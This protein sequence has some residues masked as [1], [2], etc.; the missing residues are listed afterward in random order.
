MTTT[1]TSLEILDDVDRLAYL[2][3]LIKDATTEADSIK[4]RLRDDYA[5]N[6]GTHEVGT[7]RLSVTTSLRFSEDKARAALPAD[8]IDAC[9]VAK[10][11]GALVKKV[12]APLVY[13]ALCD[14]STPRVA[15]A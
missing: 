12:V 1:R 14:A 9:T 6:P 5:T 10:L 2:Q 3:T 15:V 4:A 11:D 7:Y 13:E 8:L